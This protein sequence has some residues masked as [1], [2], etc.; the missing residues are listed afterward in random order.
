M[1]VPHFDHYEG[2]LPPGQS[3]AVTVMSTMGAEPYTNPPDFPGMPPVA[4][5]RRPQSGPELYRQRQHQA[6]TIIGDLAS[7]HL[8]RPPVGPE[9]LMRPWRRPPRSFPTAEQL[10]GADWR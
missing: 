1:T 5:Y 8:C 2:C 3:T 9:A 6:A 7:R 4:D 10:D